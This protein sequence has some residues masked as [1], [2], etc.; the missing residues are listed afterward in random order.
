MYYLVSKVIS[1]SARY[2]TLLLSYFVGSLVALQRTVNTQ[3]GFVSCPD[4][5]CGGNKDD[6]SELILQIIF[7]YHIYSLEEPIRQTKINDNTCGKSLSLA[8][9]LCLGFWLI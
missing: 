7:P 2:I 5:D 8:L 4:G 1:Y 3:K 6:L 9:I